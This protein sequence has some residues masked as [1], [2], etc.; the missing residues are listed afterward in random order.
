MQLYV[1]IATLV[2]LVLIA[3]MHALAV[4][5]RKRQYLFTL[6]NV[7][8]H[9]GLILSPLYFG[10]DIDT[11]VMLFTLSVAFYSVLYLIK[12]RLGKKGGGST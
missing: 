9:T 8:L 7:F 3:I 2:L 12:Y 6:I 5:A 4:F 11:V 10:K 1:N